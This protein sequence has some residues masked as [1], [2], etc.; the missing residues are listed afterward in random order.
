[1]FS[2]LNIK[3]NEDQKAVAF[4]IGTANDKVNFLLGCSESLKGFDCNKIVKEQI[5]PLIN[6]G[7][8]GQKFLATGTGTE[9]GKIDLTIKKIHEV[10]SKPL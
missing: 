4:L 5:A 3:N 1:I 7:G 10:L 9:K 2:E 6:G 8:G